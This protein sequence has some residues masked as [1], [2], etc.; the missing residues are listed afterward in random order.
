[1][2]KKRIIEKKQEE[3]K[4]NNTQEILEQLADLILKRKDLEKKIKEI[5]KMED[6]FRQM[7]IDNGVLEAGKIYD[8][9]DKQLKASTI[10]R[11]VIDSLKV[12][13]K[14]SEHYNKNKVKELF[15]QVFTVNKTNAK[16]VLSEVELGECVIDEKIS[17]RIDVKEKK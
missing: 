14:I 15:N 12:F 11:E 5:K 1:M 16:K 13:R 9:G 10:T 7:L 6:E 8:L 2:A 4:Q 3:L 17:Y